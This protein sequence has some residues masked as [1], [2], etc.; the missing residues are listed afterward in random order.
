MCGG[1]TFSNGIYIA[2]S[3]VFLYIL[4]YIWYIQNKCG[5]KA[6]R[7]KIYLKMEM[8]LCIITYN[9]KKKYRPF[10]NKVKQI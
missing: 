9:Q 1:G 10:V 7:L 8:E 3:V 4:G 5:K 2:V 6:Y